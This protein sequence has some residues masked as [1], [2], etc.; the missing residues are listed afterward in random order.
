MA[1]LWAFSLQVLLVVL[2][3]YSAV[4]YCWQVRRHAEFSAILCTGAVNLGIPYSFIKINLLLLLDLLQTLAALLQVV[5][6]RFLYVRN[7][8]A[9][10]LQIRLHV[11]VLHV[12]LNYVDELLVLAQDHVRL[13]LQLSQEAVNRNVNPGAGIQTVAAVVVYRRR[14]LEHRRRTK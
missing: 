7:G 2:A 4:I 5:D 13:V 12:H 1:C 11:C 8:L 9:E 14:S 6:C 10:R 3:G